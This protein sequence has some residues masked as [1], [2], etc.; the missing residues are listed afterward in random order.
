VNESLPIP[1]VQRLIAATLSDLELD[2]SGATILTEA[3]TNVFAVTAVMAAAAGA[4]RVHAVAGDSRFGTA[5]AAR[6][7]VTSLARTLGADTERI[8]FHERREDVPAAVDIVT[9]LGF[10]RPVDE[11]VVSR[12]SQDGVVSVMYEAWEL[13]PEDVDL[14]ACRRLEVPVAGVWEDFGDLRVFRSCGALALKLCTEAG[15]EIAG[16]RLILIGRDRFVEA[17]GPAL[18]GASARVT[19]IP[20]AADLTE[21]AVSGADAIVVADYHA[22]GPALAGEVGPTARQLSDWNPAL[23]VVQFIGPVA[24]SACNEAGLV[25]HPD[26]ELAPREMAETLGHLGPRPVVCL[27][28]AGL[29]VGELLWRRR[30]QGATFGRFESLVQEIA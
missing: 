18:A 11:V 27:H 12:L 21:E 7:D 20:S 30:A 24:T 4:E 9:N 5:E 8:E 22:E 1:R 16:N 10:V 15:L 28:G 3:A 17:I 2:L 14:G 26:R 13:R 25:V 29:K 23:R 19:T 6:A